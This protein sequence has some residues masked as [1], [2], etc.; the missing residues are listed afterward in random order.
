[1][2]GVLHAEISKASLDTEGLL[3]VTSGS[4]HRK[5]LPLE[6]RHVDSFNCCETAAESSV[7]QFHLSRQLKAPPSSHKYADSLLQESPLCSQA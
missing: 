2:L 3:L 4:N 1:M 5:L 6:L 7:R